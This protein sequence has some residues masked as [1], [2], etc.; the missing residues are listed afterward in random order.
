MSRRPLSSC[1]VPPPLQST[2]VCQNILGGSSQAR[3]QSGRTTSMSKGQGTLPVLPSSSGN[4]SLFPPLLPP[5]QSTPVCRDVPGESS[6]ARP[7]YRR[8]TSMSKGHGTLPMLPIRV[9]PAHC[10]IQTQLRP[11]EPISCPGGHRARLGAKP[12]GQRCQVL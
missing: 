1:D 4:S 12:H 5:L 10:Y 3:P 11:A 8:T 7:Q 6:Q 2:L 9:G